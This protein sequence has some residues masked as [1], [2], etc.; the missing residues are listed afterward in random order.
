MRV[1]PSFRACF[2]T[3]V[4]QSHRAPPSS[5]PGALSPKVRG[6]DEIF[7]FSCFITFWTC[8]FISAYVQLWY[9]AEGGYRICDVCVENPLCK[10][11]HFLK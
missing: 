9:V 1:E 4:C 8:A 10:G 7:T 6:F 5:S 11:K 2:L 3:I